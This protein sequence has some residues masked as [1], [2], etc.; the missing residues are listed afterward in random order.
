MSGLEIC[1]L[2]KWN[3]GRMEGWKKML[4]VTSCGSD[5]RQAHRAWRIGYSAGRKNFQRKEEGPRIKT[6][7]LRLE[8]IIK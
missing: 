7:G 6:D 1:S 4:Q 5:P 3:D 2:N 8:V